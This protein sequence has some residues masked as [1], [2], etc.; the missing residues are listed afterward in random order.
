[1]SNK[2]RVAVASFAL[3]AALLG[4]ALV[5]NSRSGVEPTAQAATPPP[6]APTKSPRLVLEKQEHA[7]GEMD[8]GE[9]GRH[10][11]VVRNAGDADL[12]LETLSTTCK[13]TLAQLRRAVVPPGEST[14]IVLEWQG[15]QPAE[16]FQQ[17]ARFRT[18]DPANQAFGLGV[19]GR[20]RTRM[21]IW[22]ELVYFRDIPRQSERTIAVTL[23]SQAYQNVRIVDITSTHPFVTV[24]STDVESTEVF[25]QEARFSRT[26]QIKCRTDKKVGPFSGTVRVRYEVA[27]ATLPVAAAKSPAAAGKSPPTAPASPKSAAAATPAERTFEFEFLGETV[28][29]VSLHGRDVVGRLLNFGPVSGR[30]GATRRA[31]VHIRGDVDDLRPQVSAVSPS[32]LQVRVGEPQRL[33]ATVRRYPVDV[34]IPAGAPQAALSNAELGSVVLHTEHP[35]Y[36]EVRF[37][38]SAIVGP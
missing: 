10:E 7:F 34:A 20:I 23:F 6:A 24:T 37:Q 12:T 22:P 27:D 32:F 18:N 38:V 9:E 25:Q 17:G 16:L 36:P 4:A 29:D 19:L 33:T 21:A 5:A 28:G 1:M 8:V 30:Q 13:C 15:E 35:D 2:L 14:T 26:L 11:F 31:Y 3:S